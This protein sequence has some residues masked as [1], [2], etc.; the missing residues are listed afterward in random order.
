MER[1]KRTRKIIERENDG[2][3]REGKRKRKREREG[4]RERERERERGRDNGKR[5]RWRCCRTEKKQQRWC[6]KKIHFPFPF[7]T[8]NLFMVLVGEDRR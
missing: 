6:T 3:K 4:E 5:K 7:I 8:R 1:D 2:K